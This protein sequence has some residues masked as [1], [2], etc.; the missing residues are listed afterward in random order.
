MATRVDQWKGR[1]DTGPGARCRPCSTV[2]GAVVQCCALRLVASCP[3]S[4]SIPPCMFLSVLSPFALCCGVMSGGA[5]PLHTLLPSVGRAGLQSAK[6]D[7][8]AMPLHLHLH[9]LP[10][11]QQHLYGLP[12]THIHDA[13]ARSGAEWRGAGQCTRAPVNGRRCAA[14][15]SIARSPHANHAHTCARIPIML[16]LHMDTY[17]R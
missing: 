9:R 14:P 8:A 13:R 4:P 6:V 5:I 1:I 15:D 3:S 7:A 17:S 10:S 12:H 11:P 2:G 16:P